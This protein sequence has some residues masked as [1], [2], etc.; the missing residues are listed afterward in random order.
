MVIF[1]VSVLGYGAYLVGVAAAQY[2]EPS[3]LSFQRPCT[4]TLYV[5]QTQRLASPPDIWTEPGV[6]ATDPSKEQAR[7]LAGA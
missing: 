6:D 2:Q 4:S 7:R 3:A 1:L 5:L